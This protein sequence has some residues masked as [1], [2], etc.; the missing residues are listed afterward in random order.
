MY[1]PSNISPPFWMPI[2]TRDIRKLPPPALDRTGSIGGSGSGSQS[3]TRHSISTPNSLLGITDTTTAVETERP[4]SAALQDLP[5]VPPLKLFKKKRRRSHAERAERQQKYW[6]EYDHPDD[7]GDAYVLYIDPNEKSTIG[8]LIDKFS[9]LWNRA[10]PEQEALLQSPPTPDDAETSDEE[11]VT[12]HFTSYGTTIHPSHS[13]SRPKR[14]TSHGRPQSPFLPPLTAI[15]LIASVAILIVAYILKT[16]SK[17]KY[18]TKVDAGVVFAIACSIAFAV[19]GSG[20]LL[21]RRDG[22]W[23]AIVVAA[24]VLV[25]DALFSGYLLA[26]MLG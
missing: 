7:G 14:S 20:P 26:W 22:S 21:S 8:R 17:H 6:N 2:L 13:S 5:E 10:L 11:Q 16:T 24:V 3:G 15:C 19:I 1:R 23:A 12:S 9:G 18:A 4:S 25:L